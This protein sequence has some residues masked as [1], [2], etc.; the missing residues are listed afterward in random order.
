MEAWARSEVWGRRFGHAGGGLGKVLGKIWGR[1]GG[2]L[3]EEGG[4]WS[5]RRFGQGLGKV[6][7]RFGGGLEEVWNDQYLSLK[8][9]FAG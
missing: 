3:V 4:V 5:W 7:G 6:W 2:G 9:N 1:F 8:P